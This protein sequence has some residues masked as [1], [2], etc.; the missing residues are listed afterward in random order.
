MD[1]SIASVLSLTNETLASAIVVIAASILL[2]NLTRSFSNPVARSSGIVLACVTVAY[3][4]DVF[5]ALHPSINIFQSTLRLQWLGIAFMPAALFH[6]SDALLAT[7]GLHSRGRRRRVT[8]FLYLVSALFLIFASFSN[9]LI[10]PVHV[11]PELFARDIYVSIRAG[12]LFPVYIFYFI[13][14]TAIAFYNVQ[15]ARQRCLTRDTRRRMGYLQIAMLTPAFGIFPFAVI[16]GPGQEYSLIGLAL[17]NISNL[18]VIFMLLFLAYPLSFFGSKI[19]DRVVKAELLRFVLRGPATGLLALVTIVF[20]TPA[21]RIFS[22]PGDDFMPFAVVAV[23]LLWQWFVALALPTLERYLVYANGDYDQFEK[24]QELTSRLLTR[25][26]LIQL[27]DANLAASCDYLRVNTAFVAAYND[28]TLELISA[29]GPARPDKALLSDNAEHIHALF[30]DN[31]TDEYLAIEKWH[32]YWILPLYG[33]RNINSNYAITGVMGIQARASEVDL[34]ADELEM[35]KTFANRA[36][37]TL[38]DTGLQGEIFAAVEGLLPQMNITRKSAA[39]IEFKQAWHPSAYS[40]AKQSGIDKEQFK[41]QVRAALRH[42]WGG[43]GLT[44]SRLIELKIVRDGIPEND[45]NSAKALRAVLKNAIERQ[46]PDGE[47][48]LYSPEWMLYNILELRFIERA[49]VRDVAQQ[50]ALSE[51]TLYRR[52]D[53]AINAIAETILKMEAEAHA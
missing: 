29:I 25:G 51:P 16:L 20:L 22:L 46:K 39:D 4:C 17:V 45:N 18:V 13:S 43:S 30:T 40:T 1:A 2:Y 36:A 41:E 37:N 28:I 19:P 24:L 26:D 35:L 9:L 15:R 6:L 8:R 52:Q 34:N 32:G 11:Q 31:L 23:V 42:Y 33:I 53:E 27:L 3:I 10:Q 38:D 50:L 48:K 12:I 5:L 14:I 7:T 49:K 47:R 21:T 44:S